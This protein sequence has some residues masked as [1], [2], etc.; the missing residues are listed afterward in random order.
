MQLK[1][2]MGIFDNYY[3]HSHYKKKHI[4]TE[5]QFSK[6]KKTKCVASYVLSLFKN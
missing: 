6:N 2:L 3:V 1:V 5:V 4:E